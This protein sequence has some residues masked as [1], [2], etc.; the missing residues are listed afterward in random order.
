M[1]LRYEQQ[2]QSTLR[3]LD[4]LK[5]QPQFTQVLHP[6]LSDSAGHQFWKEVCTT[7]K[8][9]GLASVIFD[10]RYDMHAVRRFCDNLKLFKLGFSWGGPVSLVMLYDLKQ[11]RALENTHLQQGLLVRFCIG[12]EDPADL[13]QDIQNALKQLE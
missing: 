6:S 2:S 3:L 5:Q 8:S 7:G 9:A 11:M 4:W 12:L 10:S 13:I 1:S